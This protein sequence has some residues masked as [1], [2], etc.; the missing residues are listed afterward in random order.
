[1]YQS[2]NSSDSNLIMQKKILFTD[3]DGTLMDEQT[4]SF[5]PALPAL[6]RLKLMDVPIIPC[7]SKTS[8]EVIEIM[9]RMGLSGP[10]IVEN[11]S[12][13]FYP[14]GYFEYD[15]P[16]ASILGHRQLVLGV[17]YNDI[18]SFFNTLEEKFKLHGCV[19]RERQDH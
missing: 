16:R 10:F 15:H 11:G 18:L 2:K 8:N 9:N 12:A 13:I 6:Q 1:M 19:Q 17:H 5:Q 14:E 7:T 3:L 4:Y